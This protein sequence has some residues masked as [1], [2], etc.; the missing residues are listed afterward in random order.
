MLSYVFIVLHLGVQTS[1]FVQMGVL[2]LLSSG[3]WQ[4]VSALLP[5]NLGCGGGFIA[6]VLLDTQP[7]SWMEK[8]SRVFKSYRPFV[9]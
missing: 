5:W 8:F 1:Q 4:L 6:N 3:Q 2:S 7:G 9:F